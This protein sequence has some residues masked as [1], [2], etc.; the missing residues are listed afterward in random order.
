MPRKK[1]IDP[2]TP[3]EISSPGE[4]TARTTVGEMQALADR[5]T[6][7]AAASCRLD[8][9]TQI[10][11]GTYYCPICGDKAVIAPGAELPADSEQCRHHWEIQS[12]GMPEKP[13][14]NGDAELL[15]RICKAE[16]E[17]QELETVWE[18][19]KEDAKEAKD[20]FDEAVLR[21]R[22]L[23]QSAEEDEES[24][25]LFNKNGQASPAPA[26]AD[27]EALDESWKRVPLSEALEGISAAVLQK[28]KDAELETV[29]DL[30]A[31]I[32]R[33]GQ[34]GYSDP[35]GTIKGIGAATAQKVADALEAFWKRRRESS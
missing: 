14:G 35:L 20:A 34:N 33:V 28:L 32:E 5:L 4:E 30:Q 24:M 11:A 7:E 19:R 27:A 13:S 25:P 3:V 31:F 22:H 2:E 18:A 15:H 26:V 17:V 10:V 21:L 6:G 12:E 16:R 23:I 29:G 1:T 9:E 8:G